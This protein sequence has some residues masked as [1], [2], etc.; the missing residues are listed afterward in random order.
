M[1]V[2][3]VMDGKFAKFF[4]REFASAAAADVWEHPQGPFP[5]TLGTDFRV[6]S[7]P[8]KNLLLFPDLATA[9]SVSCSC[10]SREPG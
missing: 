4:A 3:L 5:I 1:V 7:K 10:L 2:V 6:S 9:L 8:G